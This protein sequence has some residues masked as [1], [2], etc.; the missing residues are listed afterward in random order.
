MLVQIQETIT[1][2]T[3]ANYAKREERGATYKSSCTRKSVTWKNLIKNNIHR[4][5]SCFFLPPNSG[6]SSVKSLN[7]FLFSPAGRARET[8]VY[9]WVES[10]AVIKIHVPRCVSVYIN[11][12]SIR[13]V[14]NLHTRF[15]ENN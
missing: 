6:N 14:E 3:P 4:K 10:F 1:P 15:V 8:R 2:L 7:R 12:A 9:K 13:N 5:N 11:F